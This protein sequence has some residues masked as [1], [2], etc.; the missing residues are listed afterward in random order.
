MSQNKPIIRS[1]LFGAIEYD[2][3]GH[4]SVTTVFGFVVYER[5]GEVKSLLG[6]VWGGKE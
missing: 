5:L 3:F 4:V 1:L 2:C 6:L